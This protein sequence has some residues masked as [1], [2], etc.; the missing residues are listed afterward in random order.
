MTIAIAGRDSSTVDTMRETDAA[1]ELDHR[2]V[3]HNYSPLPVVAVSADGVWIT[4]IE[5]RRYLDCLKAVTSISIFIRGSARPA[6]IIM[7]AG[8]TSPKYLR[9]TGQHFGKSP[10]SGST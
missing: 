8:R 4:D 1:I 9:S 6:A 5:G 10:P 3:A 7:A 2:H